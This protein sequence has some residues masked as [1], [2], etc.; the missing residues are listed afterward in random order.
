MSF[1]SFLFEK[2]KLVCGGAKMERINL[3]QRPVILEFPLRGEWLAPTTPRTKIPS[4]GTNRF[5]LH[6]AFDFLQINFQDKRRPFYQV[7]FWQYLLLGVPLDRYYCW[8]EIIYAPCDGEIVSIVDG[9]PERKVHW[10]RD[11][12]I[13]LRNSWFFDE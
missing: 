10:L 13:A 11:T 7:G 5:G 4:H 8:G 2:V 9:I 1:Y 6:Y 3:E 12:L